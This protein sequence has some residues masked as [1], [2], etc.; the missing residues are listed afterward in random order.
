[1]PFKKALQLFVRLLRY[2]L[3]SLL[4]VLAAWGLLVVCSE[5]LRLT[6]HL[7]QTTAWYA[8]VVSGTALLLLGVAGLAALQKYVWP[9]AAH[10][11]AWLRATRWGLLVCLLIAV[12][13]AGE[14]M[15]QRKTRQNPRIAL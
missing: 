11:Q 3:Y 12:L 1:M 5:S 10:R 9:Y 6:Q 8:V 4:A 7:L 14:C 2:G 13:G 15:G